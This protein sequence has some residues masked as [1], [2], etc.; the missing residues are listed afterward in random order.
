MR[1]KILFYLLSLVILSQ[2]QEDSIACEPIDTTHYYQGFFIQAHVAPFFTHNL[3]TRTSIN[4]YTNPINPNSLTTEHPAYLVGV[5]VGYQTRDW[6]ALV[7]LHYSE[8]TAD[9]KLVEDR[10]IIVGD[11]TNVVEVEVNYVNRYQDINIPISFGYLT[12]FGRWSL[13]IKAG[14]YFSFNIFNDG[15]TY[16]FDKKEVIRLEENFAPFLVSYSL[17]AA[18]KY[19]ISNKWKVYAEPYYISGINSM[20]SSSPIYAW[21]QIHYGLAVG[22]EYSIKDLNPR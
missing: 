2:A 5:N 7:G 15:Y 18:L 11:D 1:I 9:Y 22:V 20:W 19:K 3:Y 17:N 10:E 8:R 4:D 21:K 16:D 6:V 13:A 12:S 14:V